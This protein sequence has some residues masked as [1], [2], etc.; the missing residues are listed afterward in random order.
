MARVAAVLVAL[1]SVLA[2]SGALASETVEVTFTVTVPENTPAD[3]DVYLA[4][5][6]QGWNPAD[7]HFRLQPGDDGRYRI[8]FFVPV[9]TLDDWQ[10]RLE[11]KFTRGS[12]ESVEK[13]P[14]GEE[15][16]NRTLVL[17]GGGEAHDFT[18][19]N[20]ADLGPPPP[21][22]AHTITGNVFAVSFPD[23][24][25]GR[26]VW[27]YLPPGYAGSDARYPVLYFWDGQNVFD[28]ATSFA[29]EWR[30]DE[31]C[32]RLIAE[33][34]IRPLI[35][36]GIENGGTDRIHEYTPW[37]DRRRAGG[38]GDAHLHAVV[39]DLKPRID[40]AFRTRT[41]P[42][43]TGICGSSLG[44]LM[45]VYAAYAAPETFARAA[46]L[47]VVFD[48]A[49]GHLREWIAGRDKPP[50]RLYFDTGTL[51]TGHTVDA[52]GNGI[53]D[54]VDGL[55]RLRDTVLEQGF[56]DGVDLMTVEDSGARHHEEAW[57]RRLPAVLEYLFPPE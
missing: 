6:F 13:G 36:V 12:W 32:E 24:L 2:A 39:R 47:S 14:R 45:A 21:P 23:V 42:E 33:G 50:V 43:D 1:A 20:W 17:R 16:S 38:G 52:N 35:V 15:L 31:T 30:A 22:A 56:R 11:F 7:R 8:T 5:D 4:G 29:G 48:W 57:A 55:R 41:G 9:G 53:D 44:G 51:E 40:G 46:G 49:G 37:I 18:V 26:R 10:N 34:R 19:A 25:D 28:A 27:I 3:A 54:H